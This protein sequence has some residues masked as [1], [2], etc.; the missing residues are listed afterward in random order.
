MKISISS[1]REFMRLSL[2]DGVPSC[3][4]CNISLTHELVPIFDLPEVHYGNSKR[5]HLIAAVS[6]DLGSNVFRNPVMRSDI[7]PVRAIARSIAFIA[8]QE[9]NFQK[10][11]EAKRS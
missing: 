8:N 2:L 4:S 10:K 5:K 9:L 6:E 11:S 3:C 7:F 1:D